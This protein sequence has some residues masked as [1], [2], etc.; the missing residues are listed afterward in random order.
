MTLE[1]FLT[2]EDARCDLVKCKFNEDQWLYGQFHREGA[3]HIHK[4]FVRM[5]D[6]ARY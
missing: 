5:P 4:C 2:H 3:I 6:I 1:S